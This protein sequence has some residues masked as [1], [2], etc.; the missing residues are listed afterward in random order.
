MPSASYSG[1]GVSGGGALR[2]C[3]QVETPSSGY[4]PGSGVRPVWA[5]SIPQRTEATRNPWVQAQEEHRAAEGLRGQK[6]RSVTHC[7]TVCLVVLQGWN[8][9]PKPQEIS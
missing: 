9:A 3:A 6:D 4:S 1:T 7:D 2:I 8:G 5:S